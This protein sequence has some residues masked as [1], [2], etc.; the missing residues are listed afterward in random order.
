MIRQHN[1]VA[2]VQP[3]I[4]KVS[5]ERMG[6]KEDMQTDQ[7]VFKVLCATSA[8]LVCWR[9]DNVRSHETVASGG[10]L[11]MFEHCVTLVEDFSNLCGQR[12]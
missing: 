12:E 6:L 2:Y 10:Q 3:L 4:W 8:I 11:L 9:V 5:D 1:Q 7:C